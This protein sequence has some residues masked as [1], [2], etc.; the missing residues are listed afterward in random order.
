MRGVEFAETIRRR[1]RDLPIVMFSGLDTIE[2]E[3]LAAG[4]NVFVSTSRA[5]DLASVVR[6]LI[7][8]RDD[9]TSRNSAAPQ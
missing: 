1:S 5:S 6:Q 8:K 7:E 2:A 3:A 9:Q 4:V